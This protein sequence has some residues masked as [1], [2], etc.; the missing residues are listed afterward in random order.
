MLSETSLKR[1]YTDLLGLLQGDVVSV[2]AL[3][4]WGFI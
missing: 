4:G 1:L 2:T 3:V